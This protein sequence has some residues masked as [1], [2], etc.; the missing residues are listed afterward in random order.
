[1][2]ANYHHALFPK[3]GWESHFA[4]RKLRQRQELI[5][6]ME[7]DIE[8][9]LHKEVPIIPVIDHHTAMTVVRD[10]QPA[11]THT[12]SIHNLMDSIG[13]A[14]K[15]PKIQPIQRELGQ[16]TI[17]AMELQLPYIHIGQLTDYVGRR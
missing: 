13:E 12:R 1:M 3:S 4:T 11:T 14:I 16:L 8:A 6:P 7:E 10:Y 5:I 17:H 2:P 15:R 9:I